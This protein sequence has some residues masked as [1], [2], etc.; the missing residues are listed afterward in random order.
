METNDSVVNGCE[1]EDRPGFELGPETWPGY[2]GLLEDV[3]A[4]LENAV[5]PLQG[6]RSP[7]YAGPE[8]ALS[9]LKLPRASLGLG[10]PSILMAVMDPS[11]DTYQTL[12]RFTE[13]YAM[14]EDVGTLKLA[15][16]RGSE[17]VRT[18]STHFGDLSTDWIEHNGGFGDILFEFPI[19]DRLIWPN[20]AVVYETAASCDDDPAFK[21]FRGFQCSDSVTKYAGHCGFFDAF[22][23]DQNA[24]L[25]ESCCASCRNDVVSVTASLEAV[26]DT[27]KAI[28]DKLPEVAMGG[29]V[30]CTPPCIFP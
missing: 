27:A 4:S 29:K 6:P 25:L 26:A 24:A 8:C 13:A 9:S 1:G 7:G 21:D 5:P 20:F 16:T 2:L 11:L 23:V 17:V 12:M 22:T 18:L 30:I 28:A 10:A 19:W 15:L 14:P 3:C